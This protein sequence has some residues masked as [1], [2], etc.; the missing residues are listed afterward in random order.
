MG[1]DTPLNNREDAPAVSEAAELGR[2][3]AVATATPRKG[4]YPDAGEFIIVTDGMGNETPFPINFRAP[5]PT[6]KTGHVEANDADSFLEY[7]TRHQD[8]GHIY[9]QM[10]P[11]VAFIGVLN[12]HKAEGPGYR[13]H[14]LSFKVAH[15]NEWQTWMSRNGKTKAFNDNEDFALFLQD[16]L[17]DIARPEP[18]KMMQIALNFRMKSNVTFN[19]VQRL[20][21]GNIDIGYAN[22]VEASAGS[23][24][25]GK[26]VIP[27]TFFIKIPVWAGLN[28]R[29]Y[30][31]E[32]R[33]RYRMAEQKVSLW[34][35]LVRPHKVVEQAF[36]DLVQE[37]TKG[38]KTKIL[39]GNPGN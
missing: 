23:D 5:P 39:F 31:I 21:D 32:A 38:A 3:I 6:R 14:R 8:G 10:N 29:F 35:E 13:D 36:G 27:E 7:W 12:D 28:P 19:A 25:G 18:A 20:A 37:I 33:F 15:S 34:Y 1:N 9:A 30:E 4:S 24:K 17:P 2:R 26:L 16:N 11:H 22:I